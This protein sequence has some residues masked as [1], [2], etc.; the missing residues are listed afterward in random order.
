MSLSHDLQEFTDLVDP[1]H[2]MLL[3]VDVQPLFTSMPLQPP[4]TDVLP[5]IRSTIDSSREL[6]IPRTFIRHII[7]EEGRTDVWQ[8]QIPPDLLT[9][10]AP[11]APTSD[12]D[13]SFLP[14][15]GDLVIDKP[16]YSAFVRTDLAD[17]LRERGIRTVVAVGLTTDIC[18]S[19]TVRDAF[20]HGFHT[21]TL[22]DCT[23]EQTMTRHEAGL[24]SLAANFGEVRTSVEV[25]AAW[26]STHR[27]RSSILGREMSKPRLS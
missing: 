24:A 2:T 27:D 26:H 22:S 7:T 3:V 12:F 23:A 1:R 17:L 11:S 19:S 21:V 20:H 18:V 4:L 6:G 15:P 10:L 8:R 9:L 13:P 25:I 16:T 5:A 14:Q